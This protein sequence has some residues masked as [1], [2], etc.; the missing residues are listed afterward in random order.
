MLRFGAMQGKMEIILGNNLGKAIS[1]AGGVRTATFNEHRLWL[2]YE[3]D[4]MGAM[5][6]LE[7]NYGDN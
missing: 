3:T 1:P 6:E 4:I 7:T 2:H 5:T